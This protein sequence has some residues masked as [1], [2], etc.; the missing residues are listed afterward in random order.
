MPGDDQLSIPG[1][2]W[3]HIGPA[4]PAGEDDNNNTNEDSEELFR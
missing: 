3:E 4:R 1:A 2:D